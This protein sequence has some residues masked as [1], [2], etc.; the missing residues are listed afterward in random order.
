[1]EQVNKNEIV[2]KRVYDIALEELSDH[3]LLDLSD[4]FSNEEIAKAA[5]NLAMSLVGR[6]VNRDLVLQ[7][8]P[9]SLFALGVSWKAFNGDPRSWVSAS[10][11]N[12]TGIG[13]CEVPIISNPYEITDGE[14]EYL[15]EMMNE[16]WYLMK[17]NR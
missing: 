4:D 3:L 10:D 9:V 1:M 6:G 11:D 2:G 8:V 14:V 15:I 16:A 12:G 5:S 7:Q 17:E 13:R